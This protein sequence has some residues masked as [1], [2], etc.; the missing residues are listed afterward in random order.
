MRWK[1]PEPRPATYWNPWFAWHPVYIEGTGERV[2]LE[3]VWRHTDILCGSFECIAEHRYR[4]DVH[5]G[6]ANLDRKG[7]EWPNLLASK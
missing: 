4:S 3:W 6:G 5:W 7:P 2:W 1:R